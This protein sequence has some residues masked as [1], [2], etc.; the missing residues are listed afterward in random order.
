MYKKYPVIGLGVALLV[1]MYFVS[2]WYGD[3]YRNASEEL[4]DVYYAVSSGTIALALHFI[5]DIKPIRKS[6][7]VRMIFDSFE[8]LLLIMTP[9]FS[10]FK[11]LKELPNYNPEWLLVLSTAGIFSWYVVTVYRTSSKFGKTAFFISSQ[12]YAGLLSVVGIAVWLIMVFK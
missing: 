1:L 3:A 9:I 4:R 12:L 7:Q 8:L 6:E 5:K 11:I 2:Q 10:T